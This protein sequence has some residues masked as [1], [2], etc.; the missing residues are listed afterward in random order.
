MK[1]IERKLYMGIVEDNYDPKRKGRIKVRVQS[2]YNNIDTNDI[3]FASPFMD[4]AGKEYKIPAIG[5]IVNILFLTNDLY[6]PYYIYSENYNINLQNKLNSLN[7]DEYVNFVA[8]LFDERT[9]I[10]ATNNE[11]TIDHLYNKITINNESINHEL[12]DNTQIL[13]LGDKSA[14]QDAVLGNN[15][16]N[17]MD[18]FVKTLLQPTSL[19]GNNSAPIIKPQLDALL[20]EY[21]AIRHTFV[22]NHVKIVDNNKITKLKRNPNT[23]TSKDDKYLKNN[24]LQ[25]TIEIEEI[26]EKINKE[27]INTCKKEQNSKPTTQ[28]P[29]PEIELDENDPNSTPI[30]GSYEKRIINGKIY[31]VNDA[32]REQL[33]QLEKK[34][35][36]ENNLK[37]NPDGKF[38]GQNYYI[39]NK[40]NKNNKIYNPEEIENIKIE[41]PSTIGEYDIWLMGVEKGKKPAVK[42]KNKI[43]IK[44][45]YPPIKKLIDA[46]KSDGV[47]IILND[48]FR[49]YEDQ[50]NIRIKNAPANKKSDSNFIKT[51]S[52]TKFRPY[53][54]RPGYSRHH[55]GIAFDISTA[56]GKNTAY[57]W[58]EKNALSFGFIRT[59]KNETW[60]WEY[61]PW[62]ILNIKPWD[63][64]AIVPKEHHTWNNTEDDYNIE[65]ITTKNNKNNSINDKNNINDNYDNC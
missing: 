40:N 18:K 3:P 36:N 43:V 41:T 65:K 4:I 46:A 14:E 26:Q 57:K 45:Y 61:K 29:Q 37:Y 53:T 11:F 1:N 54:G 35:E 58:L 49:K 22:S 32:N 8:L 31:I 6:D 17:W 56:G 39:N 51:A 7:D 12:K 21:Q 44:D 62:E 24:T 9:Q 13:N 50:Y 25:S 19:L 16:F 28:L 42:L 10:H 55:Y 33:D 38:K 20:Q 63:K 23:D 52:S 5:K 64:Y 15:W 60:H 47:N 48:A 27:K 34:Y 59:V 2:L 30:D